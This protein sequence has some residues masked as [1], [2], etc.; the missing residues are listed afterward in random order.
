MDYTEYLT[1]D[2]INQ[3]FDI[4][5]MVIF[6]LKQKLEYYVEKVKDAIKVLRGT[7]FLDIY[8]QIQVDYFESTYRSLTSTALSFITD[9]VDKIISYKNRKR[10]KTSYIYKATVL[11]SEYMNTDLRGIFKQL[12]NLLYEINMFKTI[13]KIDLSKTPEVD[14]KMS[15]SNILNTLRTS[16]LPEDF[17]KNLNIKMSTMNSNQLIQTLININ[18]KMT[19]MVSMQQDLKNLND[20]VSTIYNQLPI[21]KLVKVEDIEL[22]DISTLQDQMAQVSSDIQ[23]EKEKIT[24]LTQNLEKFDESLKALKQLADKNASI[25]RDL[26]RDPLL[27]LYRNNNLVQEFFK[28][29]RKPNNTLYLYLVKSDITTIID[30]LKKDFGTLS[31]TTQN[32]IE[33][34]QS[35]LNKLEQ[36]NPEEI[37]NAV[38]KALV[39]N[40]ALPIEERIKHVVNILIDQISAKGIQIDTNDTEDVEMSELHYDETD[41]ATFIKEYNQ[42]INSRMYTI[43][44]F[45]KEG[46]KFHIPQSITVLFT[47]NDIFDYILLLNKW[48]SSAPLQRVENPFIGLLES[49]KD[50]AAETYF[51]TKSLEHMYR[52]IL[53]TR[54]IKDNRQAL[55]KYLQHTMIDSG[56]FNMP[57]HLIIDNFSS[58]SIA[59]TLVTQERYKNLLEYVLNYK[60]PTSGQLFKRT[61]EEFNV[62]EEEVREARKK[63]KSN[64]K[65]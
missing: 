3:Y 34:L 62:T 11:V 50:Q 23:D 13:N 33:N 10:Y 59:D 45:L 54:I 20:T 25:I 35:T 17:D 43:Y 18:Q 24:N 7:N 61:T 65:S 4:L 16:K 55:V 21:D 32:K 47:A 26:E 22:S 42:Y 37:R 39:E 58:I 46:K 64:I 19:S 36:S 5:E 41:R 15:Y 52:V 9:L 12:D 8:Q 53:A 56:N 44:R 48:E 14:G 49:E 38:Q 28:K 27:D 60:K 6:N 40:Q 1:D 63:K 57:K 30:D 2:I 31:E 51:T 29:L